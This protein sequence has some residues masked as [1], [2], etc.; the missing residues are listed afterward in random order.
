[1]LIEQTWRDGDICS[2][3]LIN[4]DEI[5][6]RIV[7]HDASSVTV[8]QPLVLS[9][10][11]EPTTQQPQLQMMPTLLISAKRDSKLRIGINQI[12]AMA[13]SE[14]AACQAYESNIKDLAAAGR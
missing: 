7:N 13:P 9:V 12:I 2:I 3:K 1:M 8:K 5:V 10:I 4:G 14:D 11:V 6:A